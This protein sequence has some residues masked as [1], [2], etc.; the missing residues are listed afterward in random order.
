MRALF[1]EARGQP[2]GA[3][4]SLVRD[5]VRQWQGRDEAADDQTLVIARRV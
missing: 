1:D 3:M 4:I 5:R 2:V